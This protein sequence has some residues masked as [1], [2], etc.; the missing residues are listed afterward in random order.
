MRP[1]IECFD[2]YMRNIRRGKVIEEIVDMNGLPDFVLVFR[3][4]S[5]ISRYLDSMTYPLRVTNRTAWQLL[6]DQYKD[7]NLIVRIARCHTPRGRVSIPPSHWTSDITL[8]RDDSFIPDPLMSTKLSHLYTDI[9]TGKCCNDE[10]FSDIYMYCDCQHYLEILAHYGCT[11]MIQI[12]RRAMATSSK[13]VQIRPSIINHLIRAGHNSML[14]SLILLKRHLILIGDR[15][16]V[17]NSSMLSINL[18]DKLDIILSSSYDTSFDPPLV[19]YPL[20]LHEACDLGD[21]MH[22][23]RIMN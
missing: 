18:V 11:E 4:Y 17:Q 15:T 13:M 9:C 1:Q 6:S 7:W 14:T 2:Y 21:V 5:S 10:S 23:R 8:E 19:S 20:T 22:V 3:P 16:T 12:I